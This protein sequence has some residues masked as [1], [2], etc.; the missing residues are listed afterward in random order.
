MSSPTPQPELRIVERRVY[1]G[2]NVW[3]YRP[4]IKLVVDL[5]GLE[6]WP[7]DRLPGF[8][9]RL[10]EILPN[11]HEHKC[12][13]RHRGGFVE[14]LYEGTWLGHVAEHVAL[15][16][17]ALTGADTR[18]GKTR[19]TGERGRYNV[20][21]DY[22]VEQVALRAGELAV[23]LVNHLVGPEPGF[24]PSAEIEELLLFARRVGFGP[25]TRALIE[26]AHGRHIP[27]L[28]LDENRSL[29]QLGWG[30]HQ[31]RVQAAVSSSTSL[32]ASEIASD[33]ALCQ[34]LLRDAGVP[35]PQQRSVR[36]ADEAVTAAA[37]IGYPVVLKPLD[38]N[39]GRGVTVDVRL[40]DDVRA[41]FV[42]AASQARR[43]DVIVERF[44]AGVDFRVLVVD[45]EV[46]A[47]A[48]RVPAHVIG[49]GSATVEQLVETENRDPRRGVG[50][51]SVLTRIA[52]TEIA[53]AVLASQ[54]YSRASI[55][56]RGATVFL[57]DTANLSTGGI[58]IDCTG[59]VH[60]DNLEIAR[61][62]ALVVGL[63]IAGIDIVA[64]DLV[65]PLTRNGGAV[66]EV[67]AGPGFRMHTDP[68]S[69]DAQYVAKAVIDSLFEPGT[70]ARIPIVAVTG[71]NGKT[72]AA[73]MLA[74]ILRAT[75]K[76]V[77]LTST[78]GIHVDDR[79]IARGDSSGPKSAR[80]V[81]RHPL[82]E[83]A[84]FE[85]ARGGILREGL[86]YD[87]SD[88]AVVLNVS[89]D[90]LGL[91][92]V[93]T[94]E[95]LADVK[96]VVVEGVPRNGYAVLNAEDPLV[97]RMRR[98]CRGQII[99]F[100]D[101]PANAIVDDHCARG[102]RAVVLE[103]VQGRETIVVRDGRRRYPLTA[104]R[105]VP[106]TF[107]GNARMNVKNALAATAAGLGLGIHA[108]YIRHGLRSFET[109]FELARGR[110][111]VADVDGVTLVLDYGHNPAAVRAVG[112]FA[113][114][115]A[116]QIVETKGVQPRTIGVVG[117]AGDRRDED[118]RDLA[119]TAAM[120]FDTVVV[121]DDISL[122]GRLPGEAVELM[123][124][125]VRAAMRDGSARCQHL[126]SIADEKEAVETAMSKANAPDI[127]VAFVEHAEDYWP[128]AAT[129]L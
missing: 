21:Y 40:D 77:G 88:V 5:G 44:I 57:A 81:L 65:E 6:D 25:T 101:Q 24:D 63:D 105:A 48:R 35:V 32:I 41:A 96:Q 61:T 120:F 95:Q 53:D 70:Q 99:W 51:E 71:T 112:E 83:A 74:S 36:T 122:R 8:S 91:G 118:L 90:H 72:T 94:V 84:V 109:S 115:L 37:A 14:R 78:E 68:S 28:R 18:R 10:L 108:Q 22:E 85:V 3:S 9:D 76:T 39:H 12:S 52:L 1:R 62:A 86:G 82:V 11:L 114:N 66:I 15:G 103:D 47:A 7:T 128:D 113:E 34:R 26:E 123:A 29:V 55:P 54:G 89:S 116:R 30:V 23:R 69:G 59:S 42:A 119:R 67:N 127:V 20:I 80:M 13:R 92:G 50:H 43:G 124:E 106:S 87:Y 19:G 104:V 111:N 56:E 73:R 58:A 27:W 17:Q 110:L 117:T 64:P 102:G 38:G 49:D 100:S 33:K 46:V 45:G 4:A 97:V 79:L 129:D 2:A 125:E 98:A 107:G 75:G 121:K 93:E 31:R 126:E 60:P 16:L